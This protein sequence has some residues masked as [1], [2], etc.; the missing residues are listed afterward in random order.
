MFKMILFN[1][2]LIDGVMS[3]HLAL[4]VNYIGGGINVIYFKVN[5]INETC[6]LYEFRQM[7]VGCQYCNCIRYVM[8]IDWL[9][10]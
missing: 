10:M 3:N 9:R 5:D 1:V 4:T 6:D 7:C 8:L 2:T